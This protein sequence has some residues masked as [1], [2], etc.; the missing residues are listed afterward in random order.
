M[1]RDREKRDEY[2]DK[3]ERRSRS[4]S[5]DRH[6]RRDHT[7]KGDRR[8]ASRSIEAKRSRY[9]PRD[10]HSRS[11]SRDRRPRKHHR[12]RS[13]SRHAKGS[14]KE[15]CDRENSHGCSDEAKRPLGSSKAIETPKKEDTAADVDEETAMLRLLGFAG[16]QSTKVRLIQLLRRV[17]CL[18]SR[19]A[20]CFACRVLMS[21]ART[22]MLQIYKKCLN[23]DST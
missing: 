19:I 23:T 8:S 6:S 20:D 11:R 17:V 14:S 1:G 7:P 9:R 18:Y 12:S 16:F 3:K 21:L 15:R 4:R 5:R 2:L 13:S 10:R 22:H